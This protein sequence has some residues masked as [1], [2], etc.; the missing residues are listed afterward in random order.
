MK[1]SMSNEVVID[2]QT[3]DLLFC[4]RGTNEAYYDY[5]IDGVRQSCYDHIGMIVRNPCFKDFTST[6]LYVLEINDYDTRFKNTI[7]LTTFDDFV[8]D[9]S[10][11]DA[12]CWSNLPDIYK[13]K[14]NNI[15][16]K[17]TDKPYRRLCCCTHY[18]EEQ[19]FYNAEL[20]AFIFK[21]MEI[22]KPVKFLEQ[23]EPVD[24]SKDLTGLPI[25]L[26]KLIRLM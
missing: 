2:V 4:Y 10:R 11:I 9:R 17:V 5:T 26:G 25:G 24:F 21:E 18:R 7:K 13:N 22:F 20:I 8:K 3:G 14:L 6:G 1:Q 15:Y 23:Y 12:R 16:V 19:F